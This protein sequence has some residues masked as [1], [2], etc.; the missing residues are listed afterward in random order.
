[1]TAAAGATTD[2]LTDFSD[3]L[4][5]FAELGGAALPENTT[6]DGKS[7]APLILGKADDGPR[8]WIMALGHGPAKV[9][10]KGVRGVHD[11]AD[12][13]IR[14]K[15]F[16]VWVE[17]SRQITQLY[18]LQQD[19]L[20][21]DNLI[22]SDRADCRAALAKFQAVVDATPKVDGRPQYRPRS[23]PSKKNS[24]RRQAEESSP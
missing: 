17:P 2:A 13:V 14:D 5:T 19:P 3:L 20:E 18:D 23:V 21:R 1:M 8:E 4:P 24:K 16:K 6:L 15:R 11:Y 9:D 12:R 7:L 10:D 22:A